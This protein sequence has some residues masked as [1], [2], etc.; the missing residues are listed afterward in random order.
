M[1]KK[2]TATKK[3]VSG[4]EKKE[5]LIGEVT[6]YYDKIGVLIAKFTAAVKAGTEIHVKGATTDFKHLISSMQ[7]EH[8]A[9][10][11]AKPKMQVG[12]KVDNVAREGDKI[13]QVK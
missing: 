6:H 8:N 3:A 13:F 4:G 10:D 1:P 11:S 7:F 12:I 5:K 2:I 9:I